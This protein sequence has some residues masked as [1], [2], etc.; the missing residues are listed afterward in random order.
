MKKLLFFIGALLL[1]AVFMSGCV[2]QPELN[3]DILGLWTGDE[4]GVVDG[5]SYKIALAWNDDGTGNEFWYLKEGGDA[6]FTYTFTWKET[7]EN[8]FEADYGGGEI[9]TFTLV[10]EGVLSDGEYTYSRVRPDTVSILTPAEGES[11]D[12]FLLGMW[13]SD[14]TGTVNNKECRIVLFWNEDGKG[15]E[16]WNPLDENYA[17]VAYTF[18]WEK[19]GENTYQADYGLGE[20]WTFTL[21]GSKL[22]DGTDYYSKIG[23]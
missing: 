21:E 8:V 7:E 15:T 3:E 1:A 17:E 11:A 16:I 20:I 23:Y 5:Q 19:I 4:A 22:C 10:E 12:E 6:E 2:A 18:V 14:R 9:W 13:A